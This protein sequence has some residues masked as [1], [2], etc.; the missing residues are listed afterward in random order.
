[1]NIESPTCITVAYLRPVNP[2]YKGG[3]VR[4]LIIYYK[5]I[6]L[7]RDHIL[8][9][10]KYWLQRQDKMTKF[11]LFKFYQGEEEIEE[12]IDWVIEEYDKGYCSFSCELMK[13][14]PIF[15]YGCERKK[16][17]VHKLL[18]ITEEGA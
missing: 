9:R 11:S 14:C 13:Q 1:M 6:G 17:S 18:E 2:K 4:R 7:S 15:E 5:F 3:V 8:E 10:V 12:G 16:C